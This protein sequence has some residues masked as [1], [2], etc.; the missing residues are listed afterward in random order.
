[1]LQFDTW[2]GQLEAQGGVRSCLGRESPDLKVGVGVLHSY[3]YPR[4]VA[5]S[6]SSSCITSHSTNSNKICYL[7]CCHHDMKHAALLGFYPNVTTLRSGLCYHKSVCLSSVSVAKWA[8][9]LSEPQYL[10]G[11]SGWRPAEAR[12]QIRVAA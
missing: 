2:S 12:D 7:Q 8:N 6:L 4:S 3:T 1:M 9:T 5:K 10:L 11:L